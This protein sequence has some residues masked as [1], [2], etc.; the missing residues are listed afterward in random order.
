MALPQNTYQNLRHILFKVRYK[1]G[2]WE[3]FLVIK[4]K[5]SYLYL[6]L[7]YRFVKEI[8]EVI[9]VLDLLIDLLFHVFR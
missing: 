6:I 7:R 3:G 4:W 1:D 5:W 2:Y 8:N 9:Q